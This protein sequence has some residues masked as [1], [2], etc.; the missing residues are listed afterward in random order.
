M[1]GEA[2]RLGEPDA[3]I[4]Q[5]EDECPIAFGLLRTLDRRKQR[6]DLGLAKAA[7]ELLR[8][9]RDRYPAERV[10]GEIELALQP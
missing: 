9:A 8:Y 7:N 3:G 2:G 6:T 1:H 4:E 5:K 10:V